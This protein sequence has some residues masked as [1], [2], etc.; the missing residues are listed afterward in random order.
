[1]RLVSL[2]SNFVIVV[3]PDQSH[4][5]FLQKQCC[6][7]EVLLYIYI[8]E[9]SYLKRRD[10][11]PELITHFCDFSLESSGYVDQVWLCL[12][13]ILCLGSLNSYKFNH[14]AQNTSAL[15]FG[16][17]KRNKLILPFTGPN[18]SYMSSLSVTCH[19]SSHINCSR[20]LKE[21]M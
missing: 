14:L 4:S 7:I 8:S 15:L 1:M 13:E 11:Q 2:S 20:C 6:M 3:F 5:L 10:A 19:Q 21:D 16:V 9:D 12:R 17:C 18:T